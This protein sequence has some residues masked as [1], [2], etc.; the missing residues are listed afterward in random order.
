MNSGART[1]ASLFLFGP[2]ITILLVWGFESGTKQYGGRTACGGSVD[3]HLGIKRLS[4][5]GS[6][7]GQAY[8]SLVSAAQD[9]PGCRKEVINELIRAM[10][11]PD[12]DLE[13]DRPSFFLWKNGAQLLADLK[14]VEGLDMLIDHLKDSDGMFSAS[15]WHQPA[16]GGVIGMG[17]I[18]VPKLVAAL[19][20]K[21]DPQ[22]RVYTALCLV[23]IGGPDAMDALKRVAISDPHEC[24]RHFIKLSIVS[25]EDQIKADGGTVDRSAVGKILARRINATI[26]D[27]RTPRLFP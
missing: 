15:M 19:N 2:L 5:N 4:I 27:D 20:E 21:P 10:N 1:K 17:I 22:L 11:K 13:A 8:R 25:P 16:V 18:A 9:S 24:V 12:V 7:G 26:C 6:E 3:I 23:N 14:A